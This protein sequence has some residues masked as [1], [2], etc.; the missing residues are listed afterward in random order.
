MMKNQQLYAKIQHSYVEISADYS[1]PIPHLPPHLLNF[2][3]DSIR[4]SCDVLCIAPRSFSG[5]I[6]P[7]PTYGHVYIS[8]IACPCE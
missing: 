3:L 8:L 5:I 2:T 7:L 1:I 4:N 6:F